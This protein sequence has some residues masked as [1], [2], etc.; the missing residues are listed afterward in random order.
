LFL[1]IAGVAAWA[2]FSAGVLPSAVLPTALRPAPNISEPAILLQ[3]ENE[4]PDLVV[5]ARRY[6]TDPY[7]TGIARLSGVDGKILWESQPFAEPDDYLDELATDGEHIF[8]VLDDQLLAYQAADGTLL[9]TTEMTDKLG[10]CGDDRSC[11]LSMAA[12]LRADVLLAMSIDGTLQAYAAPTGKLLWSRQ[13][14]NYDQG[15]F[16]IRGHAAAY[17]YDETTYDTSLIWFDLTTG[18]EIGRVTP[19]GMYAYT[20]QFFN[21]ATQQLYVALYNDL[22]LWDLSSDAPRMVWQALPT[23]NFY[24]DEFGLAAADALY[25]STDQGLA[26]ISAQDGSVR[27]ILEAEDY[28]FQPLAIQ[29]DRLVVQANWTR[30]TYQYELWGVDAASGER[31]WSVDLEEHRP[32][33]DYPGTITDVD[34]SPW[35]WHIVRGELVVVGFQIKPNRFTVEAYNLESGAQTRTYD[36]PLTLDSDYYYIRQAAGWQGDTLWLLME[37]QIYALDVVAGQIRLQAP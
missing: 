9:W 14:E 11:L 6:D 1:L 4:V 37:S 35:V 18:Q 8:A 33:A 7:T 31:I 10:Y 20:P 32:L 17:E 12:G 2:F 16:T 24:P 22:T 28:D 30:G 34:A 23:D 36:I 3:T 29:G 26:A 25:I 27:F 15:L 19:P 5:Q 21:D 13:V